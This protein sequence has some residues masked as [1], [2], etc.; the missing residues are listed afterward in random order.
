MGK[1]KCYIAKVYFDPTTFVVYNCE[2]LDEALK[3]ANET[4]EHLEQCAGIS[5][6]ANL[7]EVELE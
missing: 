7:V 2:T 3:S 1:E 4:V 5:I 6:S